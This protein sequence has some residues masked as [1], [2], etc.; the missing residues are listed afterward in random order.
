MDFLVKP[1]EHQREAIQ[2]AI[3][4]NSFAF[5]FEPGC[6][7]TCAAINTLR[8]KY[9]QYN[10]ILRTIVLC[11]PIV[12]ENWRR[13]FK[14]HS[15]IDQKNIIILHGPQKKRLEIFKREA[16]IK[17]EGELPSKLG[18][19]FLTNYESLLME[20]LMGAFLAWE[21][22]V[23]L[24][25]ESHRC[26]NP[27]S[28]RTKG[29][30]KLSRQAAFKYILSGTAVLNSPLDLFPQ[31]QILVGGFPTEDGTYLIKN[32]F[33]FR[34]KYMH[35]KNAGMPRDRYFPDWI[36]KPG[37]LEEIN[38]IIHKYG[39]RVKKEDCLDLPPLVKQ[40]LYVE[41]SPT[42]TKHY[43]EMKRDFITYV[44]DT[45]CVAELAIT[46][47]L[48]L[49]QIVSGYV[50]LED[51]SIKKLK[52]TPRQAALRELLEEITSDHKVLVWA[53][54]KENYAQIKEVCEELKIKYV[55][56]HGGVPDKQKYEAVDK[57]NRDSDIRVFIGHPGS[58]GIG[59]NLVSASYS[60]F[61]SRNF[62][63]EQDLQAEA[64][65]YRGGS[66]VHEKITRIDLVAPNT[67]DE[68]ILKSLSQKQG[69]SETVLK[70][71][72]RELNEQ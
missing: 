18:K 68:L 41:L 30:L 16:F 12:L 19:I 8:A 34:A 59:I 7:K 4:R 3:P 54:F 15:K 56:V 35:D 29:A 25:D 20:D 2:R 53:V 48:R 11:P 58:G 23:L 27:S 66:E 57:F 13:E 37:S 21:T 47:A 6:G 22:E 69:I 44:N 46:K 49:Q 45:A 62:S 32:W 9:A 38:R 40:I 71:M 61:F 5:L 72:A 31:F 70:D 51:S 36:I 55:E 50:A 52:E 39:M 1:W 17:K 24:L 65:N 67:I 28:K 10:R 60:I 64:R 33:E 14:M 43:A 63:L 26:K 42:Q